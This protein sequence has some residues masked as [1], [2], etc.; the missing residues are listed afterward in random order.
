M[1][2]SLTWN[3]EE[4]LILVHLNI[5][6]K[7]FYIPIRQILKMLLKHLREKEHFRSFL[8]AFLRNRPPPNYRHMRSFMR[9][10]PCCDLK[11]DFQ[12]QLVMFDHASDTS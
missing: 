6:N 8:D 5:L 4:R 10:I 7:E 1:L 9:K 3:S 11:I 12:F 2:P